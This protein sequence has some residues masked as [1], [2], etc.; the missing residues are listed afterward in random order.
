MAP[1]IAVAASH[2]VF[3]GNPDARRK[4]PSPMQSDLGIEESLLLRR[5]NEELE[6]ELRQSVEREERMK[7]ELRKMKERLRMVEEAEERLCSELG[8]LEAEA[9]YQARAYHAQI[10]ALQEQLSQAQI[11]PQLQAR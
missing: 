5:R 3:G 11:L 9:V 4:A 7:D 6:R 2:T 10:R 1:S 8:D